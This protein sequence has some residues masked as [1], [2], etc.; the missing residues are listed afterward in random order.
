[1]PWKEC[2]IVEERLRFIARL[3]DG[4]TMA[5]LC[6]EFGIARK[7]GYKIYTRYKDCGLDGLT[8]RSR[9]PYRHANQLPLQ[10]ETLIVAL[11]KEYPRWGARD[12]LDRR[13]P[14]VRI[15]NLETAVTQRDEHWLGKDIHYRMHPENV[16]CLTSV[17]TVQEWKSVARGARRCI[18]GPRDPIRGWASWTIRFTT[19]RP[20]SPA[21]AASVTT[22]ERSTSASCSLASG[23]V[24]NR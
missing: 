1:M 15:V 13:M 10:I 14:D 19:G 7:T 5:G 2:R 24:S 18:R 3:L 20:P 6:R 16:A 4:E 12:E 21:V 17:W 22:G 9:R 11:K 8:D 23:W